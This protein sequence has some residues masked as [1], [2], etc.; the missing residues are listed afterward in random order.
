[1]EVHLVLCVPRIA[2][3]A[4]WFYQ[5]WAERCL[6]IIRIP[7][8][9]AETRSVHVHL[10]METLQMRPLNLSYVF[11]DFHLTGFSGLHKHWIRLADLP[12]TNAHSVPQ[13]LKMHVMEST[14]HATDDA[15]MIVQGHHSVVPRVSSH[16][17][18]GKV[19]RCSAELRKLVFWVTIHLCA[20]VDLRKSRWRS[21][22]SASPYL[23]WR[24]HPHESQGPCTWPKCCQSLILLHED[25][26]Q[27]SFYSCLQEKGE[28]AAAIRIPPP[29][30]EYDNHIRMPSQ[31]AEL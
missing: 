1:M 28:M 22:W 26:E 24:S 9:W 2:L 30:R 3:A 21:V 27:K 10:P 23:I 15:A 31:Q 19:P 25:S 20:L 13:S 17:S 14:K 16:I 29:C 6:C 4:Q 12:M 8:V 18:N 7:I 5:L 11:L